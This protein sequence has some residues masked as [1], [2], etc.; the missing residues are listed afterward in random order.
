MKLVIYKTPGL[1]MVVRWE[2]SAFVD[3]T[4]G[5]T[6]GTAAVVHPEPQQTGCPTQVNY[7]H[8]RPWLPVVASMRP[9]SGQIY[10]S[11][12]CI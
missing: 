6:V 9:T 12:S 10:S 1:V 7:L 11:A 5:S 2:D 8:L 3:G 4:F